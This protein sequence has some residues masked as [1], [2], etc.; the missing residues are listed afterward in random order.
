MDWHFD[1]IGTHWNIVVFAKIAIEKIAK[2]QD[3]ISRKIDN[4][5]A[6][7]SRFRDDSLVIKISRN[8]G[9]QTYAMPA[10]GFPLFSFYNQLFAATDGLVS[11]LVGDIISA[12]GYDQHYDFAKNISAV[13]R[14]KKWNETVK[15]SQE[16]LTMKRPA[17]LDFGAA[18]KGYLIDLV[19]RILV[20]DFDN[21]TVDAGGDIFTKTANKDS[22]KFEQIGLENPFNLDQAIGVVKIGGGALASSS[23]ARRKWQNNGGKFTHN[24]NPNTAKS[25]TEIAATWVYISPDFSRKSNEL[26]ANFPAMAADGIAT[27]LFFCTDEKLREKIKIPF[28]FT[29]VF[30]NGKLE[31]SQ[32]FPAEFF[33]KNDEN[34]K[35][36]SL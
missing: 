15:F 36:K 30:A 28:E 21:F 10:D 35:E 19:S 12:L 24:I 16:V 8:S 2:I 17:I 14:A 27:S 20:R 26:F 7:F 23:G 3:E 4:F 33:T 11:P 5:D 22:R 29:R 18:G 9:P 31:F 1:A 32:N 13:S 25:P 6:I 34:K